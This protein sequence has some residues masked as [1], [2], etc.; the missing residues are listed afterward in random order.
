MVKKSVDGILVSKARWCFVMRVIR[1]QVYSD[2]VVK[3]H[4][5]PKQIL[6]LAPISKQIF[7]IINE[8]DEIICMFCKTG[9]F[10][11]SCLAWSQGILHRV[12]FKK[13]K[14]HPLLCTAGCYRFICLID[15]LATGRINVYGLNNKWSFIA[16]CQLFINLTQ[17][18]MS[19][20]IVYNHCVCQLANRLNITHKQHW[21]LC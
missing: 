8:I 9:Y 21:Q 2:L 10:N 4:F 19:D 11:H 14:F 7:V 13:F 17:N 18:T 20:L 16:S 3:W 6:L 1:T 12:D 15:C 5:Q